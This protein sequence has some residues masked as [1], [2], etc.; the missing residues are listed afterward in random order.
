MYLKYLN[1]DFPYFKIVIV[2]SVLSTPHK[3][4]VLGRIVNKRIRQL[5]MGFGCGTLLY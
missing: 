2:L 3:T 5:V 1:L 4:V